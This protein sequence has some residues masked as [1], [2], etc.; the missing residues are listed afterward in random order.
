MR[1]TPNRSSVRRRSPEGRRGRPRWW[2]GRRRGEARSPAA[3]SVR[4]R[5]SGRS[6]FPEEFATREPAFTAVARSARARISASASARSKRSRS[7]AFSA[8]ASRHR[9]G[10][11]EGFR[12]KRVRMVTSV[13]LDKPFRR[14]SALKPVLVEGLPRTVPYSS[15]SAPIKAILARAIPRR[16][17]FESAEKPVL[18]RREHGGYLGKS[19]KSGLIFNFHGR[20]PSRGASGRRSG[21]GCC[22]KSFRRITSFRGIERTNRAPQKLK[23]CF[24]RCGEARGVGQL[25]PHQHAA[26]PERSGD[27]FR[28]AC[29]TTVK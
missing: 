16:R 18:R 9:R 1:R 21:A 29:A 24:R 5:S 22:A 8:R 28:D 20:S 15:K 7:E 26:R 25:R 27:V 17:G 6:A 12:Q 19:G 2:S 4:R 14:R 11:L 10:R 13:A 23:P 3:S